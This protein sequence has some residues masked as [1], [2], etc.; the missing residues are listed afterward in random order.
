MDKLW[1]L[2][3]TSLWAPQT[4]IKFLFLGVTSPF[5]WPL[6]RVMYRELL[7]GLK[8]PAEPGHSPRLAPGE[9]PFLSIP[10]A[11]HRARRAEPATRTVR[12][13]PRR[14]L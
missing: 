2:V 1:N 14:T 13:G 7:P 8:G 3:V 10:L 6:A 4:Y 11:S 9:D 12:A 5:W